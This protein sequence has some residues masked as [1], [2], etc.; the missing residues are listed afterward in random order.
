MNKDKLII[1]EELNSI[2]EEYEQIVKRPIN[3]LT[4]SLRYSNDN[5]QQSGLLLE[6]T[7]V[8]AL[9]EIIKAALKKYQQQFDE[10]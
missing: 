4:I 1:A 2:I 7:E 8:I 3:T 6:K 10:L 9:V 5:G